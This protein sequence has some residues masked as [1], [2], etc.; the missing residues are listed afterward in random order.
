MG[1]NYSRGSH[2]VDFSPGIDAEGNYTIKMES[3]AANTNIYYTLD[4]SM[5]T[6]ASIP[7]SSPIVIGQDTE[8]NAVAYIE[9]EMKEK[10]AHISIQMHKGVGIRPEYISRPH[11]KYPGNSEI[12]LLDGISGGINHSDGRWQAFRGAD[13]ELIIDLGA[14]TEV[15]SV[16]VTFLQNQPAWIF[17]PMGLEVELSIDGM[18]YTSSMRIRNKL[19]EDNEK[20]IQYYQ[21]KSKDVQKARYIRFKAESVKKCPEWHWGRGGDAWLFVDE[22]RIK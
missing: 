19:Q 21:L 13:M 22:I 14:Q 17:L 12:V 11:Q 6:L 9:E 8:I 1:V 7:Y 2:R 16:D 18:N 4:G 3:E 10:P 15:E 20:L 5:P